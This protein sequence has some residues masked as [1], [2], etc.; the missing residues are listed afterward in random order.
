M[1]IDKRYIYIFITIALIL[2]SVSYMYQPSK[3][4]G[5]ILALPAVIIAMTFHEF[6]HAFAAD[7]LG[8]ETPRNQGR[9]TLNPLKH[10]DPIGF[11]MLLFT[12]LGWGK[13]VQINPTR[14]NRNVSMSK[15][16]AIVAFAGPLMNFILALVFSFL[17]GIV[18]K[19][20]L[21]NNI[22]SSYAELIIIFLIQVI[23]MNIGLGVFNLI[24]VPP[25]DGSK[26]LRHFLPANARQWF[27]KNQR[28]FYYVFIVMWISGLAS[29]I[30]MPITQI[31]AKGIMLIVS[32]LLGINLVII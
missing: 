29:S 13:P 2:A 22:A 25:L 20:N 27:D 26:V 7:K 21:L 24:P 30:T 5:L 19:F 23:F 1:E 4:I 6:A 12:R 3:L 11:F 15:G 8:D 18:Y 28:I 9:V 10:I 32:N 14:F 17:L 31:I 16:E